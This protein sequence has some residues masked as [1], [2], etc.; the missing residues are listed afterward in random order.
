[1]STLA[2]LSTEDRRD[3]LSDDHV[4]TMRTSARHVANAMKKYFEAHL[5]HKAD[6]IRRSHA[7]DD[8]SAAVIETP[9]YKV[10]W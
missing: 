2:I 1:M 7:R 6:E 4:F 8:G 9:V 10:G 3:A 5:C